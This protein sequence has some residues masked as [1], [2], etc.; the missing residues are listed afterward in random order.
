MGISVDRGATAV[1]AHL[2]A[3][4]CA[5]FLELARES[6]V[7][8]DTCGSAHERRFLKRYVW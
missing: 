2:I 6:V 3:L 4:R 7:E 8:G 5:D 1:N